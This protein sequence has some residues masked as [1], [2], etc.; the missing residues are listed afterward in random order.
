MNMI[1]VNLYLT[2]SFFLSFYLKVKEGTTEKPISIIERIINSITMIST[3]AAP[4]ATAS[5]PTAA[6]TTENSAI[7]KLASKKPSTLT[8]PDVRTSSNIIETITSEKP[9]TIIEKIRSSL[10]A[11]QTNEVGTAPGDDDLSS[12][13][14]LSAV[15]HN[16]YS[17]R[18][19][20]STV[21]SELPA[22]QPL[23]TTS[24]LSVFDQI[25]QNQV[26]GKQTISH[27]LDILNGLASTTP[28]SMVVVT[29]KSPT[30]Q[31]GVFVSTT[32]APQEPIE[33]VTFTTPLV[34]TDPSTV[35]TDLTTVTT[36]TTTFETTTEPLLT[37]AATT[38][39]D[40]P[41]SV[42]PT[43][44]VSPGSVTVFSANDL[45]TT[46]DNNNSLFNTVT[47][48]GRV[49]FDN[50]VLT[51]TV[52]TTVSNTETV[53]TTTT[54]MMATSTTDEV[55]STTMLITN[56]TRTGKVLLDDPGQPIG[57]GIEVATRATTTSTTPDYFIFAV[58]NNNT[59]LRKRPPTVPNK[60]VPFVIVGL[61]PNNTVVRKFPNGTV[62][63]M[64][65]VIKVR[66]FDIRPDPPP[67][68]EITSNQVTDTNA[69]KGS[70]TLDNNPPPPPP[71]VTVFTPCVDV[72]ERRCQRV[73][74]GRPNKSS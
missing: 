55:T 45:I 38:T 30:N 26:L 74:G 6:G 68:I 40:L 42:P 72:V 53:V 43:F 48:S 33:A 4:N 52:P 31:Q 16:K 59:V 18:F 56:V 65:P 49:G 39:T 7:L 29:P 25:E 36:S 13:T 32:F 2:V 35:N 70:T 24:P 44:Q 47:I 34:N 3:T 1:K 67:L 51:S 12:T 41:P 50:N 10:S 62:I 19:R 71:P 28:S 61:Y 22:P 11:I 57:N 58:L 73:T 69:N 14:P 15:T 66:G 21:G 54:D 9:T 17:A 64:D 20:G 5:T 37:T 8:R 63:P 27:L 60:E 46:D 23:S